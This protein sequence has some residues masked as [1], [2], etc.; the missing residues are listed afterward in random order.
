MS[1]SHWHLQKTTLEFIDKGFHIQGR[2]VLLLVDNASSHTALETNNP[3]EVQDDTVEIDDSAEEIEELRE[4]PQG[5]SQ[6]R[7]QR[8]VRGRARGRA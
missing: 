1:A 3:T 8:R 4:Q 2:Q 5:S 6:G 7:A